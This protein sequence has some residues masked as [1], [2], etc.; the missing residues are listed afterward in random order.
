M[1]IVQVMLWMFN[2]EL[3]IVDRAYGSYDWM[4]RK[5]VRVAGNGVRI[6]FRNLR[7]LHEAEEDDSRTKAINLARGDQEPSV[8]GNRDAKVSHLRVVP[9]RFRFLPCS[10][11]PTSG[12]VSAMNKYCI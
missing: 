7:A 10:L 8:I 3:I 9:H 1:L 4:T 6:H 12:Y 11:W 2:V 5:C